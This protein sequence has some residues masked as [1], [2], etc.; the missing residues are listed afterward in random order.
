MSLSSTFLI[1]L[2]L[3]IH[4]DADV[5]G[6]FR[7]ESASKQRTVFSRRTSRLIQV[8]SRPGLL[9]RAQITGRGNFA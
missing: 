6:T 9:C 3:D 5:G 7:E 8:G 1:T 2:S 4:S